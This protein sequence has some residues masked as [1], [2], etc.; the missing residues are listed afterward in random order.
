MEDANSMSQSFGSPSNYGLENHGLNGSGTV[1]WG[2]RSSALIELVTQRGEGRLSEHGA[3]V[4]ETG[5]HTG[6][7]PN[8]K[9]LVRE[10]ES[11]EQIWWGDVNQEYAPSAFDHLHAQVLDH[12]NERDLFIQ[13]AAAGASE[14]YR[15]PIRV[16]SES[17]WHSLFVRNLFLRLPVQESVAQIPKYTILHAPNFKADPAV[18]GTNSEVFIIL[19]LERGIILI[20]GTR[21]AGEIKKSIFTV[22]N[23]ELPLKGV[24]SMHCSANQ[25]EADDV[26][27]FF[28]LSGTGKTTLSSD[29]DRSLIGDDEH[30]WSEAGV[31][32][33]EGGCYAKTIRLSP[34]YEPVI[35]QATESFGTV[36]ENVILDDRSR[37]VD[38]EDGRLTENTRAAYPLEAV[39]NRIPS[40]AGGHPKNVFFLTADAFGVLPPISKLSADQAMYYF[41]SGYTSK[42]ASTEKGL[43]D[44][45]QATFSACFG[46]PFLPLHPSKYAELLGKRIAQHDTSVWLV[47][48]GWTGG[49][50]GTG[51]RIK[52]PYTRAMVTAALNGTL[53]GLPTRTDGNFGL[54]VPV[55]CPGVPD[56]ILDPQATWKDKG[57]YS[58]QA[59][60]LAALFGG[61][62]AK[63]KQYVTPEVASSGP[64][65]QG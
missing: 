28:G 29:P 59:K 56:E 36:L 45:P 40:G 61:N 27:L 58:G 64:F 35:W 20:G 13:D 24:L 32:N 60:C 12:L 37:E 42:L 50:Y 18:H 4:V 3:V 10:G 62:F 25:G 31:F 9:Y 48:T 22:L 8:D 14:R 34:E 38:F 16:V 63:Y 2:L 33:F 57:A 46:E 54:E 1:Y 17:A 30:G 52:L 26:A 21:Y 53:A 23:Y 44:E 55:S 65:Q 43:S 5:I 41:L 51:G 6:R 47:N 49:P 19:N 7:A 11:A 15:I 39:S